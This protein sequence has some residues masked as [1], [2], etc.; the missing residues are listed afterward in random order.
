MIINLSVNQFPWVVIAVLF[1]QFAFQS[2][3]FCIRSTNFKEKQSFM[4]GAYSRFGNMKRLEVLL[5]IL[6]GMLIH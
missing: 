2:N 4:A 5:L 3:L 1:A 6:N